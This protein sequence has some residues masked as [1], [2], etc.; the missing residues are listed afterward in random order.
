M[1]YWFD[2][3]YREIHAEKQTV[4][5]LKACSCKSVTLENFKSEKKNMIALCSSIYI[6]NQI[7]HISTSKYVGIYNQRNFTPLILC[8]QG[9]DALSENEVN[10][11]WISSEH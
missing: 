3:F 9:L 6:P 5:K 10:P 4:T 1:H 2:N 11:L 7:S 8:F